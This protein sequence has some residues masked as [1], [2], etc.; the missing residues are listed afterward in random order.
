[1][2]YYSE[3]NCFFSGIQMFVRPLMYDTSDNKVSEDKTLYVPL[4]VAL[5]SIYL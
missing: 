1:M 2:I 4:C 5:S 3:A